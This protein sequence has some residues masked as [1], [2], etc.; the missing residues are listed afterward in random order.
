MG[1]YGKKSV[2][3]NKQ[4]T[5]LY[6]GVFGNSPCGRVDSAQKQKLDRLVQRVEVE[7]VV[8][9]AEGQI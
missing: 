9:I 3:I 4:T 5:Y 7:L 6:K 1:V 8:P 2:I